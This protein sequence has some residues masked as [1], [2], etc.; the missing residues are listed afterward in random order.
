[1]WASS[2]QVLILQPLADLINHYHPKDHVE[3]EYVGY[4]FF[5]EISP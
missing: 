2:D 4:G 1:M 3:P 5:Y